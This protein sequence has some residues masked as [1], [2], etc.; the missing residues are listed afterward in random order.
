MVVSA[1]LGGAGESES[2]HE[3]LFKV[4]LREVKI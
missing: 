3:M 2:R 4:V 1:W